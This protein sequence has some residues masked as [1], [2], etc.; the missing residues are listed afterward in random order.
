MPHL[1]PLQYTAVPPSLVRQIDQSFAPAVKVRLQLKVAKPAVQISATASAVSSRLLQFALSPYI[2]RE[3]DQPRNHSTYLQE[4][5]ALVP[6][7][8]VYSKRLDVLHFFEVEHELALIVGIA[9]DVLLARP[10]S[11]CNHDRSVD[12]ITPCTYGVEG[13]WVGG[14]QRAFHRGHNH[15]GFMKNFIR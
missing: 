9:D 1:S 11:A 7:V 12:K 3:R 5:C 6:L 8:E 4:T 13:V 14:T 15:S 10:S 2:R